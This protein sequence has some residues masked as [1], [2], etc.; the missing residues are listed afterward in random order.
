MGMR[1]AGTKI[2]EA[3]ANR[4]VIEFV[5]NF[6]YEWLVGAPK[7]QAAVVE[8]VRARFGDEWNVDFVVNKNGVPPAIA[9]PEAVELPVEGEPLHKLATEILGH[10]GNSK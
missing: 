1:L 9:E 8:R 7:R 2:G 4:L 6:E 10:N 3:E 5:S